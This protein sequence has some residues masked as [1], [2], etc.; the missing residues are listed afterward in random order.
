MT[1]PKFASYF[2]CLAAALLI[3]TPAAGQLINFPVLAMA[4][5]GADGSTSIGAG[6]ARGLNDNSG[7]QSAIGAG[8][9][10]GMEKVS[11]GVSGGYVMTDTDALTLAGRVG[12]HLVTEGSVSVSVQTGL[13]WQSLT[14]IPDDV[15][16][17]NIPI[18]VAIRS[19]NDGPVSVWTMPRFNIARVSAGGVSNSQK[20]IGGSAGV[21]Y[22]TESGLGLGAAIDMQRAEGVGGDVTGVFFSAGVS[23]AIN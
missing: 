22:M 7:K 23:Y 15:T 10:R 21:Q 8:I 1:Q 16:I 11:F 19:N 14:F 20:K 3:A 2:A 18:G 6:F 5:G 13:G 4:P 12:V 17:L 9:T